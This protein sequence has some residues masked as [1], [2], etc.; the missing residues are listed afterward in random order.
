MLSQK[1]LNAIYQITLKILNRLS[2]SFLEYFDDRLM[3]YRT[4]T[5]YTFERVEELSI[6][7]HKIDF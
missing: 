1:T 5:S 4:D 3:I 2:D 7:F 6:R